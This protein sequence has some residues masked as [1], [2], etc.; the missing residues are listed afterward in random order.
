MNADNFLSD[1]RKWMEQMW[2]GEILEDAR[3]TTIA[4]SKLINQINVIRINKQHY[5]KS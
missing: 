3:C 2:F 5:Y 4:E 1:N